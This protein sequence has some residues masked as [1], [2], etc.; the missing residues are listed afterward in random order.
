MLPLVLLEIVYKVLWLAVVAY[1]LWSA[2]QLAQSPRAEHLT[3]VFLLVALP[4]V[5]V[6]WRYAF[7]YY[8]RGRS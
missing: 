6:P 7:E 8:V 1:P 4:I 2:D 5:A 3:Y